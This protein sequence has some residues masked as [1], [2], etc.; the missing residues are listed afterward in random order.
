MFKKY[1][2]DLVFIILFLFGILLC[3]SDTGGFYGNGNGYIGILLCFAS[4]IIIIFCRYYSL[5]RQLISDDIKTLSRR[6]ILINTMISNII[7]GFFGACFF[8]SLLI[9]AIYTAEFCWFLITCYNIPLAVKRKDLIVSMICLSV[10][11]F[12][13]SCILCLNMDVMSFYSSIYKKR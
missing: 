9:E 8:K 5:I 7:L 13:L 11:M 1:I 3:K 10:I 6:S 12:A 4:T 2:I